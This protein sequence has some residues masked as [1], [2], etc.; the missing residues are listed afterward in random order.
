MVRRISGK[1]ATHLHLRSVRMTNRSFLALVISLLVLL[2]S[3]S[4]IL[5]QQP[6]LRKAHGKERDDIARAS[7]TPPAIGSVHTAEAT[8]N[9]KL[10]LGKFMAARFDSFGVTKKASVPEGS[11]GSEGDRLVGSKM[12][13]HDSKP[14]QRDKRPS[15]SI[16]NTNSQPAAAESNNRLGNTSALSFPKQQQKQGKQIAT[17]N[18]LPIKKKMKDGSRFE[19][20]CQ[21]EYL[22]MGMCAEADIGPDIREFL[23]SAGVIEA[24]LTEEMLAELRRKE[25]AGEFSQTT[26]VFDLDQYME[27]LTV[28]PR[29]GQ[30]SRLTRLLDGFDELEDVDDNANLF[31]QELSRRAII[32]PSLIDQDRS[33]HRMALAIREARRWYFAKS[34]YFVWSK[35]EAYTL[36][37]PSI[38]STA[39]GTVV[40][41]VLLLLTCAAMLVWREV[42]VERASLGEQESLA[43]LILSSAGIDY[44]LSMARWVLWGGHVRPSLSRF[45]HRY[46]PAQ[47]HWWDVF[48]PSRTDTTFDLD[49]D[50]RDES[51]QRISTKTRTR[52]SASF[53]PSLASSSSSEDDGDDGQHHDPLQFLIQQRTRQRKQ[54][55]MLG[56]SGSKEGPTAI[57]AATSASAIASDAGKMDKKPV[58]PLH[59]KPAAQPTTKQQAR[60]PVVASTSASTAAVYTGTT[61]M[62]TK[63]I[64]DVFVQPAVSFKDALDR[65]LSSLPTNTTGFLA[66]GVP[67]GLESAGLGTTTG[68]KKKKESSKRAVRKRS[69]LLPFIMEEE[70]EDEQDDMFDAR[71]SRSTSTVSNGSETASGI[72]TPSFSLFSHYTPSYQQSGTDTPADSILLEALLRRRKP[73][74][75]ANSSPDSV[76]NNEEDKAEQQQQQRREDDH[77]FVPRFLYPKRSSLY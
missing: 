69:R 10:Q 76:N 13:P 74:L 18:I 17:N 40:V 5:L 2:A 43:P 29:P 63:P 68:Q 70:E 53:A 12:V 37:A 47:Q 57:G 56:S 25:A 44:L 71:S 55:L 59:A 26:H 39:T 61:S 34:L 8:E 9:N 52:K 16:G 75:D 50:V 49:D 21:P 64:A 58:V 30:P 66:S 7:I 45:L 54:K 65:S 60:R 4:S 19:V 1:S 32:H 31:Y 35:R 51:K 28:P 3:V 20:G 15:D 6:P 27:W 48:V 42:R 67:P 62:H 46:Q 72:A 23:Q 24:E 38:W 14:V 11:G 41:L 73:S 77:S 36:L 33:V 22:L